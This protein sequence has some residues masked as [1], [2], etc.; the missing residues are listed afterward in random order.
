MLR[1]IRAIFD[2]EQTPV[3]GT[4]EPPRDRTPAPPAPR[5][6][7]PPRY[8]SPPADALWRPVVAQA[9]ALALAVALLVLVWQLLRPLALL[10]A[11]IVV[12][13]TLEPAVSFLARRLPRI[14]A[15]LI[16]YLAL[17]LVLGGIGWLI[18]PA[19]VD[20]AQALVANAP[21]L[22]QQGQRWLSRWDVIDQQQ[23][24]GQIE[25]QIGRF[26]GVLATIP[27][28]V[29]SLTTELLLVCT[30]SIYWL[31]AA[32]A[33]RRFAL[34]LV[35]EEHRRK[36]SD[37]ISEVGW[38]VGGYFR[39]AVL[40]GLVLAALTYPGLLILGVDYPLVLAVIAFLGELVPIVG[41]IIASIPAIGIAFLESPVLAI[42]VAVF[43][44]IIQ[45]IESNILEP[46]IMGRQTDMPPLLILFSLLAGGTLAGLLGALIAIP[47]AGATRVFVLRVGAPA[48]RRWTGAEPASEG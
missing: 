23:I 37:V 38:T 20:Q 9:I 14:A 8:E 33:L 3:D 1:R 42:K 46:N 18:V 41:P 10:F 26:G 16:V 2:G 17:A 27:L 11:A 6:Q 15:V 47:L 5:P 48:V 34:S 19:M 32:P 30:M 36:A 35:P 31:I 43:Y 24:E 25:Q 4:V 21:D 29:V 12:A 7:T 40:T 39:G 13:A 44:I 45:Q 28:R 22:V